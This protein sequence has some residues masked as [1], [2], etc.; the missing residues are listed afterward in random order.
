M[1]ARSSAAVDFTSFTLTPIVNSYSI[2][3]TADVQ[4]AKDCNG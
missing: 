4:Q 3:H 1:G 2:I